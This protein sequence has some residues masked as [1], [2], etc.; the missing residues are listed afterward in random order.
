MLPFMFSFALTA[1]RRWPAPCVAA[2]VLSTLSMLSVAATQLMV[3]GP[4]G[5]VAPARDP[6]WSA[7]LNMLA[8][9]IS[10]S[11]QS[12]VDLRPTSSAQATWA[13]YNLGELAGLNGVAS[14]L[15]PTLALVA[16]AGACLAFSS[17]A[18]A[19]SLR[20]ALSPKPH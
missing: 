5:G 7:L 1:Y 11:A 2:I 12:M 13:S 14:V 3:P 16:F 9:R 17:T 20:S 4:N 6:V 18:C 10:T 19:G 8:G 15:P